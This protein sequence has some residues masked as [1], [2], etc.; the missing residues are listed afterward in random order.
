MLYSPQRVDVADRARHAVAPS[1]Q[2]NSDERAL[3][4]ACAGERQRVTRTMRLRLMLV[5][6]MR[7]DAVMPTPTLIARCATLCSRDV[8]RLPIRR[9]AAPRVYCFARAVLICHTLAHVASALI[10]DDGACLRRHASAS[11]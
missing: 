5:E 10:I 11:A 7:R 1:Q 4:E 2:G 9:H 8:R 3:C 6:A